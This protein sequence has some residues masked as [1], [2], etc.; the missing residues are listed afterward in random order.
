MFIWYH[1]ASPPQHIGN[2]N[3]GCFVGDYSAIRK[4]VQDANNLARPWRSR[5]VAQSQ[6]GD[7]HLFQKIEH[8]NLYLAKDDFAAVLLRDPAAKQETTN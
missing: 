3:S 1:S 8:Y 5:V 4:C 6:N 2:H 7:F